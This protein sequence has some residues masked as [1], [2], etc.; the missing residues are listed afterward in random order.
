MESKAKITT[1]Y[2]LLQSFYWIGSCA[3]SGY[4]AVYLQFRGAT[5]TMIGIIIGGASFASIVVS[6]FV[7]SLTEKYQILTLKQMILLLN[8]IIGGIFFLLSIFQVP[9]MWV[10][11]LYFIMVTINACFPALLSSLGMSY[12]NC[13]RHLNFGL[14][15][16]MGSASYAVVAMLLGSLLERFNP[17][18][19]GYAFCITVICFS[20]VNILLP[21][22]EIIKADTDSENTGKILMELLKNKTMLLLM[23]GFCL[24]VMN[25][26]MFATYMVNI[27]GYVGGTDTTLG[28]ANFAAALSEM[29]IMFL[30]QYLQKRYSSTAILKIS[31]V[32]FL[33]R[34]IVLMAAVNISMMIVGMLLQGPGFGLFYPASVTFVNQVLPDNKRI[35]GQTIFGIVTSNF[36]GGCGN[37]LGGYLQDIIGIHHTLYVCALLTLIGM[38]MIMMLPKQRKA[39][40]RQY[41]AAV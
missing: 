10:M 27:N 29:P 3:L 28:I 36:A 2:A 5:N 23:I 17:N 1:K 24:C 14:S 30:C 11:V 22:T 31:A 15:R 40:E 9:T 26:G 13:G 35:R 18:L 21:E 16:G 20:I 7:A 19:L 8:L 39:G 32:F 12:I 4:A 37:L 41:A 6:A 38:I 34:V 25:Y 33:L